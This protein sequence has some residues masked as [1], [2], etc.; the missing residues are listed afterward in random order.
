VKDLPVLFQEIEYLQKAFLRKDEHLL[1]KPFYPVV[2]LIKDLIFQDN[3]ISEVIL[4]V[5]MRVSKMLYFKSQ[6]VLS[7]FLH[8]EEKEEEEEEKAGEIQEMRPV[9][10]S[11]PTKRLLWE[12]VFLP[13]PSYNFWENLREVQFEEKGDL[14]MLLKAILRILEAE[15]SIQEVV[16]RDFCY[17]ID[18]YIEKLQEVLQKK[19]A[20]TFNEL[21]SELDFSSSEAQIHVVYYFLAVL[22]LCFQGLCSIVQQEEFGEIQIFRN[23]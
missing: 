5:L 12:D 20:I 21:I 23:I 22:F 11:L 18:D 17:F 9:A 6:L 14:M 4:E 15:K 13:E 10:L 7:T 2:S 19:G 1:D 8:R 3:Q 16:E